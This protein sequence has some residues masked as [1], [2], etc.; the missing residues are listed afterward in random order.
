MHGQQLLTVTLIALKADAA[1]YATTDSTI[2]S[3]HVLLLLEIMRL[4]CHILKY[5]NQPSLINPDNNLT[6]I[7][8]TFFV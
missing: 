3:R 2:R 7:K 1:Q 4:L 5:S 8:T 6:I